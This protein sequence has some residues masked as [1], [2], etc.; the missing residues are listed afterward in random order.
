MEKKRGF[1]GGEKILT[2]F[3]HISICDLSSFSLSHQFHIAHETQAKAG[4]FD[5]GIVD[6]A[7][8]NH[9]NLQ[10]KR[11]HSV[12]FF[13]SPFFFFQGYRTKAFDFCL[14]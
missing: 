9:N 13:R 4:F 10:D 6:N 2:Y 14:F 8:A 7:R 1:E 3:F 12:N 11:R 5:M